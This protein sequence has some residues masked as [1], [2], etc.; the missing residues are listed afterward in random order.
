MNKIAIQ[1]KK[2]PFISNIVDLN[3]V[4]K[5][6]QKYLPYLLKIGNLQEAKLI[7]YKP[8]K[9]CLVEYVFKGDNNFSI[10][11]KIR[12]KGLDK[13]SY[14]LQ[15]F[16]YQNGF[17]I[18][19]QDKIF[20]PQPMGIIP[21]W[22]M[23]LQEKVL[24]EI[25]TNFFRPNYSINISKKIPHIAHKLHQLPCQSNRVHSMETELKILHQK[26]PLIIP[27]FPHWEKRIFDLLNKC[28]RTYNLVAE[29]RLFGIHRDFYF[30][31]I[32]VN[33]DKY[34]LLDLDLYCLG[35]PALDIGNFVGHLIEYSFRKWQKFDSL[36]NHQN[37]IVEEF[38]NLNGEY[39]RQNITIY[40][41][42][43][44]VRHIYLSTT[45]PKRNFST[46]YLFDWCEKELNQ[47]KQKY[48][49]PF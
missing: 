4:K 17:G 9:R 49:K 38:I 47:L 1:D 40:T 34:Y 2:I 36:K 30:D 45:F 35:N 8:Q 3:C 21:E 24:G 6:F 5:K 39:Q 44:V 25:S 28:D 31:Q 26:L 42:L 18:D 15:K 14:S 48:R 10:I 20:V 11:G 7:R 46:P 23:W 12:A 19:S 22:N 27:L 16:L 43:T 41:I 29:K 13:N 33:Q 37:A 32:I